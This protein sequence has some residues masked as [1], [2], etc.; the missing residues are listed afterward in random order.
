MREK[1]ILMTSLR[2]IIVGL[3]E[4]DFDTGALGT[5]GLKPKLIV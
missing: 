5:K 3:Y 1:L 4:A 2:S